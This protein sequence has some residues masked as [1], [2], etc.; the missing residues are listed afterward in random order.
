MFK[1]QFTPSLFVPVPVSGHV[2][3]FLRVLRRICALF[4]FSLPFFLYSQRAKPIMNDSR[5]RNRNFLPINICR[6]F[7]FYHADSLMSAR[8]REKCIHGRDIN[9]VLRLFPFSRNFRPNR[10][11]STIGSWE[12]RLVPAFG[13]RQFSG[14]EGKHA[15]TRSILTVSLPSGKKKF[16]RL[17]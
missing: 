1:I 12:R 6:S 2:H 3:P 11:G 16:R 9:P 8:K 7:V 5:K 17:D 10:F 4:S 15:E 13:S 14:F